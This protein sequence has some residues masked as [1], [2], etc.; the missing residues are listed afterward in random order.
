MCNFQRFSP[1]ALR[2]CNYKCVM[3]EEFFVY[4]VTENSPETLLVFSLSVNLLQ[5]VSTIVQV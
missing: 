4:N 3:D 5:N 2:V 1:H